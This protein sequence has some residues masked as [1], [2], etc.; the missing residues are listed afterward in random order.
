LTQPEPFK[1][2]VFKGAKKIQFCLR[3]PDISTGRSDGLLVTD[4]SNVEA[5]RFWEGQLRL[6]VKDGSLFFLFENKGNQFH[7][8]GFE[9]LATLDQHCHPNTVSNAFS[10][11]LSLFN[12]VQK[13]GTPILEYCSRFDGLILEML[14]CKVAIPPILLVMLFL[15][16]L[17]VCYSTIVDQFRYRF[18]SLELATNDLVVEDVTYHDSF[19]VVNNKKDKKNP[20]WRDAS[21]LLPP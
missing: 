17:N 7:G 4:P 16:D 3:I 12:E 15:W 14:Q 8:C 10:S 9:M 19:T 20:V 18:K 11:L 6:A 13:D 1:L 5:S 2:G 21:Q